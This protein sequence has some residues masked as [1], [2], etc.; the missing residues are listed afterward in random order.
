MPSLKK[1]KDPV[2][3]AEAKPKDKFSFAALSDKLRSDEKYLVVDKDKPIEVIP[4]GSWMFDYVTGT[5]GFVKGRINEIYGR[6][7]CGKSTIALLASA[8]A[9]RMGIKVLWADA[10]QTLEPT[11]AKNLGVNMEDGTFI[12]WQPETL[13]E[14]VEVFYDFLGS[15]EELLLVIDSM[16]ALTPENLLYKPENWNK[17]MG[18][19][20][21]LHGYFL[22]G[23]QKKIN[24]ANA[25]V[26]SLNQVRANMNA[27]FFG[28]TE[29]ASGGY[30]LKHYLS[31][32]F[33]MKVYKTEKEE[34]KNEFSGEDSKAVTTM[35]VQVTNRKNKIKNP[36]RSGILYMTPGRGVDNIRGV[37]EAAKKK[38]LI[39][40]G[41]F[42][43]VKGYSEEKYSGI[44]GMLEAMHS[45]KELLMWIMVQLGWIK[46]SLNDDLD[47]SSETSLEVPEDEDALS[48]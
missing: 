47:L 12:A 43:E 39:K 38:N 31:T 6:E 1:K 23:L 3:E 2:K 5:G 4:S 9:Q 41:R 21:K 37:F 45:D 13:E 44:S 17:S 32:R 30:A 16:P 19:Q 10:E 27:G 7:S 18:S 29:Q 22:D 46:S 42:C 26:I 25:T 48:D 40:T 34:G 15:G 11:Y 28:E 8:Q 14:T 35:Q 36:Y 24:R 20:A 33:L